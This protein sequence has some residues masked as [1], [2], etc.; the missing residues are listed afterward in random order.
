MN[1]LSQLY[2]STLASAFARPVAG[3]PRVAV[4]AF[5]ALNAGYFL[6]EWLDEAHATT[7]LR[8]LA[9][10]TPGL[11][12]LAVPADGAPAI[13]LTQHVRELLAEL[14]P[15]PWLVDVAIHTRSLVTD[16]G[17]WD[18]EVESAAASLA[19]GDG[20]PLLLAHARRRLWEL[21][22]PTPHAGDWTVPPDAPISATAASMDDDFTV[23]VAEAALAEASAH[24]HLA[25]KI[26]PA[27]RT[28]LDRRRLATGSARDLLLSTPEG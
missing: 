11:R 3:D 28:F 7:L 10:S 13:R 15:A 21:T 24:S 26:L 22:H 25:G 19:T 14:G 1:Q 8:R 16:R 6:G 5:L 2:R 9:A 4:D 18:A 12:G 27:L 17:D 20:A 23:Q